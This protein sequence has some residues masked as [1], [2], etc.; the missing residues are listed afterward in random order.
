MDAAN[1]PGH[2][3]PHRIVAWFLLLCVH[4]VALW[5]VVP[6]ATAVWPLAW[7]VRRVSSRQWIVRADLRLI[8]SMQCTIFRPFMA[9][10]IGAELCTIPRQDQYLRP[11]DFW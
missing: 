3:R 11:S 10:A 5:F 4:G 8:R 9:D 1:E 7:L 6:L 2:R